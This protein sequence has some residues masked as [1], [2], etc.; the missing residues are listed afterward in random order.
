M[1][2][3]TPDELAALPS[4]GGPKYNRLVFESS[5]Y[6]RS[7]A[8]QRI[9]WYP[10]GRA[11]IELARVTDKPLFLSIGYSSCHWCHVMARTTFE[12]S[13]VV[14]CLNRK[15][16]SVKIDRD[17]HPDLDQVYMQA[18][19]LLTNQGGWPNSVFCLP[20]GQPFYAGTYFPP[21][22]TQHAMGFVTLLTQLAESWA[23]NRSDI[24]AQGAELDRVI[25]AM[26]TIHL[27]ED[28]ARKMTDHY[29]QVLVDIAATYDD[30]HGG[31]GAAPKFPSFSTLRLLLAEKRLDMVA[32]SLESMALS[33]LYDQVDGGFHRYSTDAAWRLPHF[34]K[35]L[36][37]NAQMIELY[38]KAH[39]QVGSNLFQ[40]VVQETVHHLMDRWQLENGFYST[41]MNA[42]SNGVEGMYYTISE[43][44]LR[45]IFPENSHEIMAH[46]QCMKTGNTTHLPQ[47]MPVGMNVLHPISTPTNLDLVHIRQ[48]LAMFRLAHR[49]Q[50]SLDSSYRLGENALLAKGLLLAGRHFSESGWVNKG[51]ELINHVINACFDQKDSLYLDDVVYAFD[52]AVEENHGRTDH[53]FALICDRFYD[54]VQGG[55]WFSQARHSTPMTRIKDGSDSAVSAPNAVLIRALIAWGSSGGASRALEM[56]AR[57]IH[58][59]LPMALQSLS[60]FESF[61]LAMLDY[62]AMMTQGGASVLYAYCEQVSSASVSLTLVVDC[63][64]GEWIIEGQSLSNVP[65]GQRVQSVQLDPVRSIRVDWSDAFVSAATGR[66]TIQARIQTDAWLSSFSCDLHACTATQCLEPNRVTIP[67]VRRA[68]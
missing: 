40:R 45:A 16:V 19:Q 51:Q 5:D 29:Q 32:H 11:A 56:A 14:D 6:L 3:P 2:R 53:L 63:P 47:S 25:H 64:P 15:F 62:R 49:M 50:P 38:T 30:V 12:H 57:S 17:E 31:F 22:D 24:N 48:T 65:E 58:V 41:S 43:E 13:G 66:V 23:T 33:G 55:A 7:H 36:S 27:D 26:N 61:W 54:D 35:M 46:Y 44:E 21:D 34:E 59:F 1:Q 60:G 37:D 39:Q 68:N 42:E 52:A 8:T 18:T 9:H 4:D 20:T 28:A 67:V 10:W